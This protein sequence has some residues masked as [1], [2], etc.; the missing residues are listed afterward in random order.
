MDNVIGWKAKKSLA[1]A[2]AYAVKCRKKKLGVKRIL[3]NPLLI[4]ICVFVVI[5][6]F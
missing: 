3:K 4:T 6:L 5:G 1:R 2:L